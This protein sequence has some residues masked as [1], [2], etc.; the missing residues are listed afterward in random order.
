M[1]A[2]LNAMTCISSKNFQKPMHGLLEAAFFAKK[3]LNREPA[4]CIPLGAF[5][6]R[7]SILLLTYI[8]NVVKFFHFLP[9]QGLNLLS[10]KSFHPIH[11]GSGKCGGMRMAKMATSAPLL[12]Q[13]HFV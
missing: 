6:F 3:L 1:T 12:A 5:Q 9:L 4:E 10:C 13:T 8:S 7:Q 11:R 2:C